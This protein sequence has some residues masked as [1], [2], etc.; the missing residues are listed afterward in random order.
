MK[1]KKKTTTT[2]M[3]TVCFLNYHGCVLANAV[4]DQMTDGFRESSKDR[5]MDPLEI[6][7]PERLGYV[8]NNMMWECMTQ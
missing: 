5:V 7:I 8:V 3:D 4:F 1:E 6:P 2:H